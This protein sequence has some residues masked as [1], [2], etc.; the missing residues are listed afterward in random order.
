MVG[1]AS[2]FVGL[3][4]GDE[5]KGKITDYLSS[6]VGPGAVVYTV[7][8]NG[9]NNAGH[10]IK[11]K[12]DEP[13]IALHYVPSGILTS[14]KVVLGDGMVI[15]PYTL[16][17]EVA[18]L[19]S[20]IDYDAWDKIQIG[21]NT[22][23]TLHWH[24]VEDALETASQG[25]TCRGIAST[26]ADE[27]YRI[28]P[29]F[30]F[31]I[32]EEALKEQ[33]K[34]F[35]KKKKNSFDKKY[36]DTVKENALKILT[37]RYGEE[38]GSL[39][40]DFGTEFDADNETERL[41]GLY[42]K[43]FKNKLIDTQK[44]LDEAYKNDVILNFEGAQGFEL[45]KKFG[46]KG[47]N[48]STHVSIHGIGAG[49]GFNVGKV[50]RRV[51]ILKVCPSRVGGIY[52]EMPTWIGET[53]LNKL[54]KEEIESLTEG[55]LDELYK[56][57]NKGDE[58]ALQKI[59][60]NRGKEYGTTTGRVRGLG[61]LDLVKAARA[62]EVNDLNELAILKG[63]ILDGIDKVKY[64]TSY[65]FEGKTIDWPPSN[66]LHDIKNCKPVYKTMP[67][68]KKAENERFSDDEWAEMADKGFEALPETMQAFYKDILSSLHQRTGRKL[69]R[70]YISVSPR[71][72]AV[73]V[74]EKDFL[75]NEI[76]A[77]CVST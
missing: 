59:L 69:D 62:I 42:N 73:A 30:G 1:K 15:C 31:M 67:G 60:V 46:V 74:L 5:G 70:V 76:Y 65:E 33:L 6:E 48:T 38:Q 7:R 57:A 66:Q 71:R 55:E 68:W 50:T 12:P 21:D 63:D 34:K 23:I 13:S 14:E 58:Y 47:K 72:G 19:N 56:T 37:N 27:D 11:P 16:V 22:P 3:Q 35:F 40:W 39:I 28:G 77:D 8:F 36:T 54:N 75:E 24:M 41:L 44:Y 32:S 9:G 53:D 51:G 20:R 29:T 43:H 26:C 61:W 45:D 25:S 4:W 49:T 10:T 2:A 64:C 17:E 52:Q 18:Y